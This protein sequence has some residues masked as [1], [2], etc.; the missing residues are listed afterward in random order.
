MK[1]K[2]EELQFYS[3]D[4][5]LKRKAQYNVIFGER[6][7]GKTYAVLLHGLKNFVKTGKQIA[8]VRRYDDDIK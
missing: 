6:S 3:L 4:E 1:S 8:I 2:N 5:I 7:N